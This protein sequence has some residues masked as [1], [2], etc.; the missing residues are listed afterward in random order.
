M[1]CIQGQASAWLSKQ[2]VNPA[3][4]PPCVRCAL[5]LATLSALAQADSTCL[6]GLLVQQAASGEPP[7][8][9]SQA[10]AVSGLLSCQ[11]SPQ[12]CADEAR[13]AV[14]SGYHT[15]KIKVS[16][17]KLGFIVRLPNNQIAHGICH[18]PISQP[19]ITC[20]VGILP[21]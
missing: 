7:A 9:Q 8:A 19:K 6:A 2:L 10:V 11:G 12:A 16:R 3:A 13:S 17:S 14:A 20:T 4:L 21:G 15:L 1:S 5:E 18:I